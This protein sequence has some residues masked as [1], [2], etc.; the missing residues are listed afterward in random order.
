[1]EDIMRKPKVYCEQCKHYSRRKRDEVCAMA[2]KV[3]QPGTATYLHPDLVM[4]Q[5]CWEKNEKNK[6]SDYERRDDN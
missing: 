2:T 5:S 3:V 4:K 6:C 1:M